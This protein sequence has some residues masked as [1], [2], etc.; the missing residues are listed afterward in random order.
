MTQ[1]SAS[2]PP[3]FIDRSMRGTARG[4]GGIFPPVV[5]AIRQLEAAGLARGVGWSCGLRAQAHELHR[6]LPVAD[7]AIHD[8]LLDVLRVKARLA[9][10]LVLALA[11][12]LSGL[13]HDT[14]F[15]LCNLLAQLLGALVHG[16]L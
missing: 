5:L 9:S 4:L 15:L 16:V 8:R 14:G 11:R 13:L 10:L 6:G 12:S 7:T 2:P 1:L 3:E